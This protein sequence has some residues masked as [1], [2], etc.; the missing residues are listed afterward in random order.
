[1]IFRANMFVT[2]SISHTIQFVIENKFASEKLWKQNC[3]YSETNQDFPRS[4]IKDQLKQCC[5]QLFSFFTIFANKFLSKRNASDIS[6]YKI[7]I[8]NSLRLNLCWPQ[9]NRQWSAIC[10]GFQIHLSY[11]F[12]LLRDIPIPTM[13]VDAHRRWYCLLCGNL[14]HDCHS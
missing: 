8:S 10:P 13:L 9:S 2:W 5:L 14:I 12:Q 6:W 1:M 3:P 7:C 4:D 11:A